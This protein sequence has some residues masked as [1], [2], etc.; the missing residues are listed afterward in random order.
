MT[1]LEIPRIVFASFS[2][3][4][5]NT[6]KDLNKKYSKAV[7]CFKLSVLKYEKKLKFFRIESLFIFGHVRMLRMFDFQ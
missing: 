4:D 5:V 6:M 1:K 7:E 3:L 2:K